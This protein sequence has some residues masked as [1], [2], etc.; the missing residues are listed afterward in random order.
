MEF[1]EDQLGIE[2]LYEAV[3]TP[4]IGY[5]NNALK[6]KELFHRDQ[7][8]IVS[9]GEV[10][11]VD[12]FTG[13]V[14]A[15]RRYNEGMHQAIEAKEKV[16]I[17]DENQT[18]ATITLQNYFRLYEKLAGMTGTAST[19]AAELHQTYKLGVV[20]IP[21][22]KPMIRDDRSDVIYKTE[23][24]K[25][26]A[27][28]DDIAER[29]EAGQPV[30]V[31]HR[32]R[33][34]V[35]AAGEVP[36]QARHPARGAEREEPRARGA[37]RRPGRAA[38]RGHRV[39]QHGRPRH[40]HPARRQPRVHRRRD[41][42][43][44]RALADGDAGGVRGGLGRGAR[45]GQGAGQGRARAGRRGRRALRAGHRAAREPADRQPAA[46]PLR[47]AGRPGRVA[48]LPLPR[49]RPD[50]PVQRADARVD[51]EHAA[52]ARRPADRVE[53]G[54]PGDPLGADPG[55][56]AELRGPQGRPQ[57]RRGAQPPAHRHLR[58]AAQDPRGRRPARAGR[59]R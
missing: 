41:A 5:L 25:F 29:H 49:R 30:L 9:N 50:A 39:D 14:L 17:K 2:N 7:Q 24:A 22:N 55:R 38:G 20:P 31:G 42:A 32:E 15:G 28:V 18:L 34:E 52:G 4:L 46:R 11:I 43:R 1:V 59:S 44:P 40:R 56:A 12:E 3:N 45:G 21:T 10:L 58:R 13:R 8:Y 19:E 51:D 36:A 6:A 57:V 53:D 37:H 27:V 47:P 26:D 54:H 16:E 48:V 23:K 35:R 33:R